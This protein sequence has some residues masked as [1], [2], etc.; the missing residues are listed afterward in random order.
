MVPIASSFLYSTGNGLNVRHLSKG[1]HQPCCL[2][3]NLGHLHAFGDAL[4]DPCP[5]E[6]WP[7]LA[8]EMNYREHGS[9][10]RTE[11]GQFS[12]IQLPNEEYEM[13]YGYRFW[14]LSC[15]LFCN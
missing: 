10:E 9:V 4:G 3:P 5:R 14:S 11:F 12:C 13:G 2:K 6:N 7:W 8:S 1:L 15:V